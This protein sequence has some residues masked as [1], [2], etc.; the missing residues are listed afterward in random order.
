[1]SRQDK[2][3][4]RQ[5]DLPPNFSA[6]VGGH[7]T[8]PVLLDYSREECSRMLRELG[9]LPGCLLNEDS[10]DFLIP[11]ILM[12]SIIFY[13]HFVE[14]RAYEGVVS[15]LR[16][17]GNLTKSKRDILSSLQEQLNISVER[18]QSEVRRATNDEKLMT[19]AY[20]IN[21]H[22]SS[23]SSATAESVIVDVDISSEWIE[24]G[25][26]VTPVLPRLVPQTALFTLANVAAQIQSVKNSSMPQ[27]S[28]TAAPSIVGSGGQKRKDAPSE[29]SVIV[30]RKAVP[31]TPPS[32]K[33]SCRDMSHP[34]QIPQESLLSK[35][36]STVKVKKATASRARKGST[37]S[38][39]PRPIL[40]LPNHNS[41]CHRALSSPLVVTST[42][43][44]KVLLL[45]PS[46]ATMANCK[47]TSTIVTNHTASKK[48][49]VTVPL[50][51]TSHTNNHNGKGFVIQTVKS[52]PN[53]T[54]NS[55]S[56]NNCKANVILVPRSMFPPS[57]STS[58][59]IG[60]TFP[61]VVNS[62]STS[63]GPKV[64]ISD[65]STLPLTN[66]V[67]G[68]QPNIIEIQTSG[69]TLENLRKKGQLS[70]DILSVVQKAISMTQSSNNNNKGLESRS[71]LSTVYDVVINPSPSPPT[72]ALSTPVCLSFGTSS[73]T[74]S[75]S[76][77][78]SI[79][80]PPSAP[81]V[82]TTCHGP[83]ILSPSAISSTISTTTTDS[84]L[85]TQVILET[86]AT[87]VR[88]KR[89][90]QGKLGA[91]QTE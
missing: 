15:A 53:T 21:S 67:N 49:F 25:R 61:V 1:M 3:E 71:N 73:S 56:K 44:Q 32:P 17:Q 63:N 33:K 43:P 10:N 76:S 60:S 27:P 77:S 47:Q 87:T 13:N 45:S 40:V 57:S 42:V 34:N 58:P 80:S 86:H 22:S 59:A 11:I 19:I 41:R 39:S 20:Q 8:W 70:Q 88:K 90:V 28:E 2:S 30:I 35:F 52:M 82:T 74:S 37:S 84:N 83:V 55:S 85:L 18:H 69:E 66:T 31:S 64:L 9:E 68:R 75:H 79:P 16:A 14:L 50:V 72:T 48:D 23:S 26:R 62:S 36:E 6:N 46:T 51:A 38:T 91:S 5:G 7:T 4:E 89:N 12:S 54:S 24:E 78:F 81:S 29:S 65:H